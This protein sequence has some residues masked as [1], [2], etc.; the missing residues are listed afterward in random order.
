M[1][2]KNS[3]RIKQV[4]SSKQHTPKNEILFHHSCPCR[5][6]RSC[7]RRH[8]VR[9]GK[10]KCNCRTWFPIGSS[11][12]HWRGC[13][14]S[15]RWLGEHCQEVLEQARHDWRE[16]VRRP[17]VLD[18]RLP[19]LPARRSS[20]VRNG[21][22]STSRQPRQQVQD[23]QGLPEVC[24]CQTWRPVHWRVRPVLMEVRFQ[25]RRLRLQQCR[26]LVRTGTLRVR[27]PVR[28]GH[29]RKQGRV[30]RRLPRLLVHYWLRQ[31]RRREL[32]LRRKC[33]C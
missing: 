7:P 9:C 3:I 8:L 19:L 4:H 24:P 26:R 27:C 25:V 10:Y 23:V 30:Q 18:L 13:R 11:C 2:I 16:Q 33:P 21:P 31:P 6:R 15:L 29:F 20:N 22:R 28:Q 32:P 1:G 5:R 17:Q 12:H 14:A